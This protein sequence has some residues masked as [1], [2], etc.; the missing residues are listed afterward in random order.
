MPAGEVVVR[1][2]L[3][4]DGYSAGMSAARREAQQTVQVVQRM[5]HATVSSV[6][7]SS[8]AL[9]VLEGGMQ[10]NIRA[11][12]RFI[13][14]IPGI[15]KALQAV[16]P[17]VGG[18]AVAGIFI[19]IGEEAA[20]A[21]EK[22]EKMNSEIQR[23][24]ES[25]TSSG[26]LANDQLALTNAKLEEQLDRLER[27]PENHL[28]AA[29]AEAKVKADQLFDSLRKDN[30]E[31]SKVLDANQSG[32]LAQIMGKAPS[33]EVKEVI[34]NQMTQFQDIGRKI[35]NAPDQ[36]T[37]DSESKRLMEQLQA[38]IPWIEQMKLQNPNGVSAGVDFSA[39]FNALDSLESIVKQRIDRIQLEK[40]NAT[41]TGKIGS[42]TDSNRAQAQLLK[43][44]E[45]DEKR[46]NAFNKLTINEEIQFWTDRIGAFTK[47]G[48]QYIAVQDKIY[49]LIAK[50]PNLFGENKKNQAEVGKSQVEGNDLLSKGA[51][52]FTKINAEQLE[53]ATRAAEKY[54]SIMTETAAIQSKN[55]AA[56]QESIIADG[57]ADGTLSD[58]AAA[59]QLAA[60]H[61]T[62]HAQALAIVNSELAKQID[63]IN[64]DPKL[65]AED[66]TNA[67][68]NAT[69]EAGKQ[70]DALNGAFAVT[71]RRDQGAIDDNT[72]SGAAMKSL[73]E[74]VKSFQD[75]ANNL[76]DVIP[77]TM[78]SLNDDIVKAMTGHGKRQDFG[79]TFQDAGSNLLKT[80]LQ[81]AE[82]KV[83]GLFGLGPKSQPGASPANPMWVQLVGAGGGGSLGGAASPALGSILGKSGVGG[84]I[85]PFLS[86]LP[87]FAGGGDV[88]AN[89]PSI[90][91]ENGPELFTPRSAGSITPNHALGGGGTHFH[92]DARGATDPSAVHSA[93]MRAAP[94]II[95]ASMQTQHAA[96]KR[97]PRGR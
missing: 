13:S 3:N 82:G 26:R 8:A 33:A 84:F 39:N 48:E 72:I 60:V 54:N 56:L 67:I 65:S 1:L 71:Q 17:V 86:M 25:I 18:I 76:K 64:S 42:A 95:A 19:R 30:E 47:G 83:L 80:G 2:N 63:I 85:Q 4:K 61:A 11:A 66:K 88:T 77:R 73:N 32:I 74:M 70:T 35:Q 51:E 21:V 43:A 28:A 90:V 93:I 41:L 45:E 7:A 37:R 96:A 78:N 91:G 97:S 24:F 23:G 89:Y 14:Q 20:K 92:I 12:E 44:D 59:Q 69:G 75:M 94:H 46:R 16:F 50:R 5:G 38:A 6:Q 31:I 55:A 22:V 9:R 62:E 52:E 40:Q 68:R 34:Q 15:G 36:A 29:L 81:G 53:R 57:R 49:D 87:H 58:L 27:K 79:K 10:G